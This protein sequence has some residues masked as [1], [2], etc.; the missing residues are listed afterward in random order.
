[1]MAGWQPAETACGPSREAANNEQ[2]DKIVINMTET[3]QTIIN[4]PDGSAPMWMVAARDAE[5]GRWWYVKNY[6]S[7]KFTWTSD[8]L[9]GKLYSQRRARSVQMDIP[10]TTKF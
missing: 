10:H 4:T 1:M 9:Y 8:K 2:E 3:F 5:T 6:R 7:G